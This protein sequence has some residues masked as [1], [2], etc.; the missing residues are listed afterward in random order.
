MS[1]ELF[2][3]LKAKYP[4]AN[5]APDPNCPRCKGKG[6]V[7]FPGTAMIKAHWS[8]CICIFVDHE[9]AQWIGDAIRDVA[10]QE[11]AKLRKGG[12]A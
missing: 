2:L 1:D 11:L 3:A 12:A 5:H 9:H 8:C 7:W 10:R 4:E 6:E